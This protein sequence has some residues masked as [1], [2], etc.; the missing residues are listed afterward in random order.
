MEKGFV[1][2]LNGAEIEA[3]A[4]KVQTVRCSGCGAPVDI[5]RDT[6]CTH[7]RAPIVVLDTAA[8]ET[9]LQNYHQ[10][11]KQQENPDPLARADAILANERN[12]SVAARERQN[13][14]LDAD[15]GDLLLD[16]VA[17]LWQVLRH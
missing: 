14:L 12:N 9:A 13:T 7:C 16:G 6:V 15:L 1:R 3:L 11:A 10:A 17:Q 4:Q 8:V 5:R 2:Q